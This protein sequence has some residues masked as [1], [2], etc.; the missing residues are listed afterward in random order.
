MFRLPFKVYGAVITKKLNE[1]KR[2]EFF[3]QILDFL[4]KSSPHVHI[5]FKVIDFFPV[6]ISIMANNIPSTNLELFQRRIK[7][8]LT[9]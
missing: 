1:I 9:R 3:L 5:K 6:I 7:S 8:L 2:N 4:L